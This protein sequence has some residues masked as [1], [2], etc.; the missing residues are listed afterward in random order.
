MVYIYNVI[1]TLF[2][3]NENAH[4]NANTCIHIDVYIVHTHIIMNLH[5]SVCTLTTI[6]CVRCY[7][8]IRVSLCQASMTATV[9]LR[10]P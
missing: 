9:S 5:Q 8:T 4:L 2:L 6:A 10:Q 7:V 3:L 1:I